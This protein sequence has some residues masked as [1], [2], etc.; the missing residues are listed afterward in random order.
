[1]IFICT[2][3]LTASTPDAVAP[4]LHTELRASVV[5]CHTPDVVDRVSSVC[6]H[7]GVNNSLMAIIVCVSLFPNWCIS[8]GMKVLYDYSRP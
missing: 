8:L 2:Y 5:N 4:C 1:M 7:G 6:R 3:T